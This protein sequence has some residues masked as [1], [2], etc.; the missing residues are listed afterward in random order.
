MADR[1]IRLGPHENE[2]LSENVTLLEAGTLQPA[3]LYVLFA[4]DDDS[5]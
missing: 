2:N 4:F 5:V 3:N 1:Q